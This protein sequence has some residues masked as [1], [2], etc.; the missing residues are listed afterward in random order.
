MKKVLATFTPLPGR[1]NFLCEING[2]KIYNDNNSTTSDA[3]IAAL[4]AIGNTKK[5]K[6]VLIVGGDNKFLNM[7]K[8]L[9]EI[10]KFCSKV[11]LFKERGTDL[12]RD[13]VFKLKIKEVDIY[14]EEG[15]LNTIRRAFDIAG[16]GETILYSPAFSSFGKYFKNEYDR[17]DKFIKIVKNLK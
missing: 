14:E 11:V 15:L 3:T 10:P 12:I 16:R 1:L 13:Q 9:L 17:G 2:I 8:L 5:R 6:I 7:S 4:R